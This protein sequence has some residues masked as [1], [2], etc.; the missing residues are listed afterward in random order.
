MQASCLIVNRLHS[1][2]AL[3]TLIWVWSWRI[4]VCLLV[5]MSLV[6]NRSRWMI[7][8]G[9]LMTVTNSVLCFPSLPHPSLVKKALSRGR[10]GAWNK[11]THAPGFSSF[12]WREEE[13][14]TG[15]V[16]REV[17][18]E[19]FRLKT[20]TVNHRLTRPEWNPWDAGSWRGFHRLRR[21]LMID[22]ELTYT[23]LK[24][25][26]YQ[27]FLFLSRSPETFLLWVTLTMCSRCKRYVSYSLDSQ[28][29][30]VKIKFLPF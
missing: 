11:K 29:E 14:V 19:W 30:T 17:M 24:L 23:W 28:R 7:G 20:S 12:D 9:Q 8:G 2:S 6:A 22:S 1:R 4:I 16:C 5:W 18:I 10:R 27:P 26:V 25:F 21:E 13:S 15:C 3:S